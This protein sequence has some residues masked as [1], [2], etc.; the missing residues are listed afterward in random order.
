MVYMEPGVNDAACAQ[1][2]VVRSADQAH[3][4]GMMAS[5]VV[6]EWTS[7]YASIPWPMGAL[8]VST[9]GEVTS[10]PA[11]PPVGETTVRVVGSGVGLVL[12][13]QAM[14]NAT[15]LQA[16]RAANDDRFDM[17]TTSVLS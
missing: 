7:M 10:M 8:K 6:P 1:V 17:M 3:A 9:I 5:A 2:S 15:M 12:S 14:V 13:L 11:A 4:I 16:S